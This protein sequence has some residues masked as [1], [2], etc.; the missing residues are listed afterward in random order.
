[1][2]SE[3]CPVCGAPGVLVEERLPFEVWACPVCDVVK[4]MSRKPDWPSW[5]YPILMF[6][7]AA[8][9]FFAVWKG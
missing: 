1:V 9:I 8:A 2:E 5:L 6:L 3:R 7:A 4:V